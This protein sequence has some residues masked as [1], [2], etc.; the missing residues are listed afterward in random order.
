MNAQRQRPLL[1][2]VKEIKKL[3][4]VD[5]SACK[6]QSTFAKPACLQHNSKTLR[7][8]SQ[9]IGIVLNKLIKVMTVSLS[10]GKPYEKTVHCCSTVNGTDRR[11]L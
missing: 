4:T 10:G 8:H 6:L 1:E 7:C 9:Q 2:G 5:V 11:C 3:L